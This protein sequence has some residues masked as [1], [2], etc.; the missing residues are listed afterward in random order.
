MREPSF[1]FKLTDSEAEYLKANRFIDS[2]YGTIM[3]E[4]GTIK[5][6]QNQCED[7]RSRLSDHLTFVGFDETYELTKEGEIL[8]SLIDKF[9]IP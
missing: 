9:F 3:I 6:T 1:L 2:P 5:L 4:N 7:I 8:E